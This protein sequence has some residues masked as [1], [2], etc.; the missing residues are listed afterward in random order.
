MGKT[1]FFKVRRN[2]MKASLR[3]RVPDKLFDL[4]S[5]FIF[6]NSTTRT[7]QF[8]SGSDWIRIHCHK[9]MKTNTRSVICYY[10]KYNFYLPLDFCWK[11][12]RSSFPLC[13]ALR[14]PIETL[15]LHAF[16]HAVIVQL[17]TAGHTTQICK[18]WILYMT[19]LLIDNSLRFATAVYDN[20]I[21][22]SFFCSDLFTISSS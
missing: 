15:F 18:E 13:H 8:P 11:A 1:E 9:T 7:S 10:I 14:V 20:R 12:V 4:T 16:Y 2:R 17:S 6:L 3:G 21:R 5:N 19:S 22:E